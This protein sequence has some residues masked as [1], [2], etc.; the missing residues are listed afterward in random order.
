M[1]AVADAAS[2]SSDADSIRHEE[3]LI[4]APVGNQSDVT[5]TA[6]LVPRNSSSC[7]G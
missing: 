1:T 6:A 3:A 2:A 7:I 4:A 5:G